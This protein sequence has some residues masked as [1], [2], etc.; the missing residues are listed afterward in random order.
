MDQSKGGAVNI[1]R[2]EKMRRLA[3]CFMSLVMIV[4]AVAEVPRDPGMACW[5]FMLA[6]YM[7]L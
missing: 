3:N 6:F 2:L 1:K 4:L 5:F 7:G